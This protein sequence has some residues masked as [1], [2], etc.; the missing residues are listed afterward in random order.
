L[1]ILSLQT[2]PRRLKLDFSDLSHQ[3][4][5]FDIFKGNFVIKKGIMSTQ[6][7]YLDGPVAY[8]SMKGD[9]DLVRRMYDLNLSIS[10]HITASL[11]VVATIA[12][13]PIAGLAAWVANKIINQSMQKISAYSYKISGPWKEPIVQQLTI[14]KKIIKK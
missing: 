9:L 2:I 4:Y 10:P 1:S 3:G 8:A 14:V 5:S 7:S 13:G 12:G 6:D 11:P